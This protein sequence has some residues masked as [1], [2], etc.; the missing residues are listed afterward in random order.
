MDEILEMLF[1]LIFFTKMVS[2]FTDVYWSVGQ[3]GGI[4]G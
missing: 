2:M 1:I 4:V 3:W